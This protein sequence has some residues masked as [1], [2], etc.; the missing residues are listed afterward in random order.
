MFICLKCMCACVCALNTPGVKFVCVRCCALSM[1][2]VCVWSVTIQQYVSK[3]SRGSWLETV[4][5]GEI[6]LHMHKHTL[7]PLGTTTNQEYSIEL[8]W[9]QP[10]VGISTCQAR[11]RTRSAMLAGKERSI[12]L[13]TYGFLT[14]MN[15]RWDWK[16]LNLFERPPDFMSK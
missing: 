1:T 7:Q 14:E 9:L 12:N 15:R 2:V 6:T 3:A 16:P 11:P 8:P 13:L 4:T 10:N 5:C